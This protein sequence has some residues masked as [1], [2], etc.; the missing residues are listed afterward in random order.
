[1]PIQTL[2][3]GF[4]VSSLMG[5][6]FHLWKGGNVW[7]LVLYLVLAWGGFW[8][9]HFLG[10]LINFEFIKV[11]MLYLGPACL[12]CVGLLFLGHWLSFAKLDLKD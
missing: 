4:L 3:M 12:L 11:G 6:I 9:G 5:A 10:Q 7:R 8:L 1:M 2:I